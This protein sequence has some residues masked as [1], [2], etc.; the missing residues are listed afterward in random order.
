MFIA[1]SLKGV[2]TIHS[3]EPS[4]NR[5]QDKWTSNCKI[6]V[7]KGTMKLIGILSTDIAS[8]EV[9]SYI[10]GTALIDSTHK[11]N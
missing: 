3:I 8:Y 6:E 4:Y 10:N 2:E 5:L 9:N 1:R 7:P 11:I